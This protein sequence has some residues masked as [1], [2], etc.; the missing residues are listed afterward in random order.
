MPNTMHILT[1]ETIQ[2]SCPCTE[3]QRIFSRIRTSQ[4]SKIHPLCSGE[5]SYCRI[6]NCSLELFEKRRVHFALSTTPHCV[7]SSNIELNPQLC[8]FRFRVVV[9][10]STNT[11][12][13]VGFNAALLALPTKQWKKKLS[14]I[15]DILSA[16]LTR[17]KKKIDNKERR[18][19]MFHSRIPFNQCNKKIDARKHTTCKARVK[20]NLWNYYTQI[21]RWFHFVLKYTATKI[22]GKFDLSISLKYSQHGGGEA[23]HVVKNKMGRQRNALHRH[24]LDENRRRLD[25]AGC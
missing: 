20:N 2:M 22:S 5:H 17:W 15:P 23:G 13:L 18:A 3:K 10:F 12:G 24:P 16:P 21:W 1:S 8:Q 11:S 6:S 14:G 25:S 4:L 7:A 19:N 9:V